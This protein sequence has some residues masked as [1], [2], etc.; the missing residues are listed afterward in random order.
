MADAQYHQIM[1]MRKNLLL[2]GIALGLQVAEGGTDEDAEGA[3][4]LSHTNG[5]L[6]C[7]YDAI[8]G[9][10]NNF[11]RPQ[12]ITAYQDKNQYEMDLIICFSKIVA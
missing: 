11:L 8:P 5:K 9:L 4:R 1:M 3:G 6:L 2:Q 12:L 7:M 10:T